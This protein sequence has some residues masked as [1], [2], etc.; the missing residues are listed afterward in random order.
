MIAVLPYV[1]HPKTAVLGR[2]VE[3]DKQMVKIHHS[4]SGYMDII[5]ILPFF[6]VHP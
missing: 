3:G 5:S 4:M 1:I 2:A 6:S